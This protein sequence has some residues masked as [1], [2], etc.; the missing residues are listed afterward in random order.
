MLFSD[1]THF[2][3]MSHPML[4]TSHPAICFSGA[5]THD[6]YVLNGALWHCAK[7]L[8]GG[9]LGG[10]E[11]LG[12]GGLNGEPPSSTRVSIPELRVASAAA[13]CDPQL[14][15]VQRMVGAAHRFAPTREGCG[16][17]MPADFRMCAPELKAHTY[18][19]LEHVCHIRKL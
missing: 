18:T 8:Q 2:P 5:A 1:Q 11:S 4:T 17:W 3:H 16:A 6:V 19:S 13:A 7:D 12:G 10:E 9:P 15:G 14:R